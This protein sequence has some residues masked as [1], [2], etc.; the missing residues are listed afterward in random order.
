MR[1]S[2]TSYRDFINTSIPYFDKKFAKKNL[3]QLVPH[4]LTAEQKEKS[5]EIATLLKQRFAVESQA[6]L[7]GIVA[8]DVSNLPATPKISTNVIK[9]QANNDLCL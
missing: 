8:I 3:C 7:Y 5:L 4:C 9:G 6:F 2:I 1:G